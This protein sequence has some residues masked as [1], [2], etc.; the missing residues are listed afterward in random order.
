M[1]HELKCWPEF[2]KPIIDCNKTFEV[3]KND[4]DFKALDWLHLNEWCPKKQEYTGRSVWVHVWYVMPGGSFGIE[5]D[6]CVMS[7]NVP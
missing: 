6:Y 3:R 4:R 1:N 7:I 5:S 2:F